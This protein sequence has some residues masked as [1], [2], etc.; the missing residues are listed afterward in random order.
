M[1]RQWAGGD[2][3]ALVQRGSSQ[4]VSGAARFIASAAV[5][6]AMGTGHLASCC[7]CGETRGGPPIRCVRDEPR[8]GSMRSGGVTYSAGGC[9]A[10]F[11]R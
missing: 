7:A 8:W 10:R 5:V 11:R 6:E 4:R 2:A 3:S 9:G 1:G